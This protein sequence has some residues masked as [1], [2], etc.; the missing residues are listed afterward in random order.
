[1]QTRS[2]RNV[3][4]NPEDAPSVTDIKPRRRM[5]GKR[6]PHSSDE[7]NYN[8][9]DTEALLS[10]PRKDSKPIDSDE[11][12]ATGCTD[13][14]LWKKDGKAIAI[15]MF[16][17]VLQGIPLG[18]CGSIPYIL[19]NRGISYEKQALFSFT[20]WPFSLKLIWAPFVDALYSK[21]FGRRKSWLIPVQFFLGFM[22]I[23]LSFHVDELVKGDIW[24]LTSLFF[25]LNFGAATQD[26][27][28]DG[29][30]L[31]MLSKENVGWASTDHW[32]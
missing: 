25:L 24:T 10:R 1:M 5:T 28:V 12:K 4:S 3:D 20:F 8:S 14:S 27:A 18:L 2:G 26:I 30:C 13:P 16:L 17:Y 19:T 32:K 22:M 23:W 15:L 6:N 7:E 31:T 11:E 29:W 21:K 9:N